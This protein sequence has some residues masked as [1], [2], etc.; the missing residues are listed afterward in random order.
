MHVTQ[1]LIYT[2]W[3]TAVGPTLKHGAVIGWLPLQQGS[4]GNSFLLIILQ[5]VISGIAKWKCL[6]TS[7]NKPQRVKPYK[8]IGW[9]H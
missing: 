6:D 4:L 2:V 7:E 8:I 9:G 1:I 5:S 3:T